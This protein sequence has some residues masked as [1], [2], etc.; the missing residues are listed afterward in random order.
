MGCGQN[1]PKPKHTSKNNSNLERT[2]VPKNMSK[3]T[4]KR[5]SKFT[6]KGS[7]HTQRENQNISKIKFNKFSTT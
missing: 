6:Q 4:E 7:K 2:M 3:F 5:N 1:V